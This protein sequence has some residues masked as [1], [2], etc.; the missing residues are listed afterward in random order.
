[1]GCAAPLLEGRSAHPISDLSGSVGSY[2]IY[3]NVRF[4]IPVTRNNIY[5]PRYQQCRRNSNL[6]NGHRLLR[7]HRNSTLVQYSTYHDTMTHHCDSSLCLITIHTQFYAGTVQYLPRHMRCC[8]VELVLLSIRNVCC[9]GCD[10]RPLPTSHH[11]WARGRWN[12]FPVSF[13]ADSLRG[14]WCAHPAIHCTLR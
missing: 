4:H 6:R 14:R 3:A 8:L 5:R 7:K 12:I 2:L 9:Q 11:G 13:L 10:A 1:M